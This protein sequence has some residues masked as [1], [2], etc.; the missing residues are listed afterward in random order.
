MLRLEF[1]FDSNIG[2]V[3]KVRVGS[4]AS[5][6]DMEQPRSE[7]VRAL[8]DTGASVTCVSHTLADKLGLVSFEL[9]D[10]AGVSGAARARTFLVDISIPMGSKILPFKN[11]PIAEY[12]QGLQD[13]DYDVLLG[14]DVLKHGVFQMRHGVEGFIEF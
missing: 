6:R 11:L 2:P 5:S 7:E 12:Q 3:I 14:R 10:V 1:D 9:I 4:G 13:D 8:I